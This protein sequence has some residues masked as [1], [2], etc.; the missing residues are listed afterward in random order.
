MTLILA[1]PH[2]HISLSVGSYF[3]NLKTDI[4]TVG[5]D[6]DVYNWPNGIIGPYADFH[7]LE[8]ADLISSLIK[9]KNDIIVPLS[10]E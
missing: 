4:I 9:S 1:Y 5:Y 2:D 3:K 10:E 7:P 8:A 6:K